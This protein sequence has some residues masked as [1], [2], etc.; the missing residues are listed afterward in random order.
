MAVRVEAMRGAGIMALGPAQ[1]P[2][3]FGQVV[4]GPVAAGLGEG[5]QE[6]VL[7]EGGDAEI[8]RAHGLKSLH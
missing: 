1:A 6:H 2:F 5:A 7:A 4:A 3:G 8:E